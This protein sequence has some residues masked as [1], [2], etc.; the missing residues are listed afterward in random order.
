MVARWGG[1]A[2]TAEIRASKLGAWGDG[3]LNCATAERT[4]RLSNEIPV[5]IRIRSGPCDRLLLLNAR[6]DYASGRFEVAASRGH[7]WSDCSAWCTKLVPLELQQRP[8]FDGW[9]TASRADFQPYGFPKQHA[10]E[11]LRTA[12]QQ[13]DPITRP[14]GSTRWIVRLRAACLRPA[15]VT[16]A[17]CRRQHLCHRR[18][19]PISRPRCRIRHLPHNIDCLHHY[20]SSESA[21]L[22]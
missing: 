21:T 15:A 16:F 2:S 13:G 19:S 9:W 3:A 7:D 11:T 12:G 20:T 22:L 4:P 5:S 10:S 8:G 1:S 14:D 18:T 17:G 6:A